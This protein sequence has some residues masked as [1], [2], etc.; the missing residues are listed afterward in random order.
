MLGDEMCVTR[1]SLNL[2]VFPVLVP[3]VIVFDINKI[4]TV[5]SVYEFLLKKTAFPEE[6]H[7]NLSIPAYGN[8]YYGKFSLP[9]DFFCSPE[10]I[11]AT[12][13]ALISTSSFACYNSLFRSPLKSQATVH[14]CSLFTCPYSL[15]LSCC[16]CSDGNLCGSLVLEFYKGRYQARIR[17]KALKGKVQ[18]FL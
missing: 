5:H 16:G 3:K 15:L 12:V 13:S 2:H 18:I 9:F 6:A 8:V 4:V 17:P 7:L 1:L 10:I 11:T 14:G